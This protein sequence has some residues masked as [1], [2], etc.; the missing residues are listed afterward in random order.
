MPKLSKRIAAYDSINKVFGI[1]GNFTINRD[2]EDI[3]K[4]VR[5]IRK[6]YTD[7]FE[8]DFLQEFIQFV[9]YVKECPLKKNDTETR[10]MWLYRIIVETKIIERFSNVEIAL[11]LFSIFM[12]TN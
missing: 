6:K 2:T 11:R 5:N 7:D 4:G 8:K 10:S 1:I 9:A 12:I 3:T